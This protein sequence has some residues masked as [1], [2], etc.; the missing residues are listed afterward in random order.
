LEEPE[1]IHI[2]LDAAKVFHTEPRTVI[3]KIPN[4]IKICR[5]EEPENYTSKL[6]TPE[7]EK[8]RNTSD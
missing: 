5:L 4:G 6:K 7:Q 8:Y 1:K 3:V 2:H